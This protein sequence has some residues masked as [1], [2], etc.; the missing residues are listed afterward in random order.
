MSVMR[1][2]W[3]REDREQYLNA[4]I[5]LASVIA[6]YV[7]AYWHF[8]DTVDA[9]SSMKP[10]IQDTT[11]DRGKRIREVE[12]IAPKTK[13]GKTQYYHVD[14]ETAPSIPRLGES[15]QGSTE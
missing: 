4:G 1:K 9:F 3:I 12:Y 10:V 15:E 7:C 13:S 8:M 11:R 2:F 6:S 14:E 5:I